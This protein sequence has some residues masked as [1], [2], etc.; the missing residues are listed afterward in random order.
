MHLFVN[1]IVFMS[2]RE[3]I[4]KKFRN[5][6]TQ[7]KP[8]EKGNVRLWVCERGSI[9]FRKVY[10]RVTFCIKMASKRAWSLST[11]N[12]SP[13]GAAHI[14]HVQQK[15]YHEILKYL[16]ILR[17]SRTAGSSLSLKTNEPLGKY[18]L[19]SGSSRLSPYA[20]RIQQKLYS[21]FFIR[22]LQKTLLEC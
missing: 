21:I 2:S 1:N 5:T 15:W 11:S 6:N 9:F 19:P 3:G 8:I 4:N 17:S 13:L 22:S 18:F 7:C 20:N 10:E 16:I 12:T 14:E